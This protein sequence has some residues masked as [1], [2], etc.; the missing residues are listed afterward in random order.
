MASFLLASAPTVHVLSQTLTED[1]QGATIQTPT[2]GV[3]A[4][5]IVPLAIW[6]TQA[7]QDQIAQY[8]FGI[9]WLI[10]NTAA[11]SATGTQSIDANGLLQNQVTFTV[12]YTPPGSTTGPLTAEA[13]VPNALLEEIISPG[14]PSPGLTAAEGIVNAALANLQA[15]AGG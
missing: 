13:D 1:A 4:T 3:I 7:G 6:G 15:M 14:G 9:E 11:I 5:T 8:M 2:H 12:A 10:D